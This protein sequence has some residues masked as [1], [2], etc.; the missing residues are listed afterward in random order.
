MKAGTHISVVIPALDEEASIAQVIA[1]VPD[2]VDRTIVAD[3]GSRDRTAARAAE[4]GAEVVHAPRRGYGSACLAGI[5]AAGM[6]DV[7]VFLD[8]DLADDPTRM[9]DLVTP[10]LRGEAELVIGSRVLGGAEAGSL[11]WAQR[12][13]NW[14]ACTLIRIFWGAHHTDLGPFRAIRREALE[15]LDMRDPDFGWTVEMQVKAAQR[16]LVVT[17]VPVTYR[18][19]IGVSKISGTVRGT[20]LAGTKIIWVIL[21]SALWE[22]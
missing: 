15:R 12:F 7:I 5:R 2:W 17:E 8:G 10:I 18:I 4:A 19:R 20:V 9:A 3:N 14:L 6:T 13:G 22:R 11:T 21:R 1:L 16:K